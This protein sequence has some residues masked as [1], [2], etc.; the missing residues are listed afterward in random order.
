MPIPI[1]IL[2]AYGQASIGKAFNTRSNMPQRYELNFRYKYDSFLQ[3]NC[4]NAE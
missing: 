4:G 3:G 1:P 2:M